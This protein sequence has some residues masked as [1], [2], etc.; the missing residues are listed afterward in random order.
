[1]KWFK[2]LSAARNDEKI[3]RLEDTCGLEGYGFYFKMLEIVAESV[4]ETDRFE[5]TYSLTRWS[6]LVN[7]STRK[8]VRFT[9]VCSELELIYCKTNAEL[10]QNYCKTPNNL[11]AISIPKLL[12]HRDN[13]TKHLQV[14]CKQEVEVEKEKETTVL[15]AGEIGISS[16]KN[17]PVDRD[18]AMR[19]VEFFVNKKGF[20]IYE[21]QTAT[22]VPMFVDWVARGVTVADVEL[23]MIT[24]HHFFKK[25]RADNP[26]GYKKFV[27]SVLIEKQKSQ[28][29]RT[30]SSSGLTENTRGNYDTKTNGYEKYR[31]PVRKLSLVEEAD[32]A[33]QRLEA[34][35][36]RELEDRAR[37]LN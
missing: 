31:E 24:A 33:C 8:W 29:D 6:K 32:L 13:H 34:R 12:K 27:N 26:S 15:L 23:A 16:A 30:G 5:V 21:A 28:N 2:H 9:I 20:K 10:L 22:T 4:D 3:A 25:T 11:V 18:M 19:W 36:Q 1:M 37:T 35:E 14:T 7:T 17:K